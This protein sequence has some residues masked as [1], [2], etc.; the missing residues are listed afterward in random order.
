[1][2]FSFGGN[3]LIATSFYVLHRT[4]RARLADAVSPRVLL[5]GFNLFRVWAITR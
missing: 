2:I 5:T 3:A 1:M 4:S